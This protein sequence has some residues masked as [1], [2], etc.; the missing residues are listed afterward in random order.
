[1][2]PRSEFVT[3]S[4]GE[5]AGPSA[6]GDLAATLGTFEEVKSARELKPRGI[7]AASAM[8]LIDFVGG[9]L[10]NINSLWDLVTKI[11]GALGKKSIR[12][13]RVTL[14][15][16]ARIELESVTRDELAQ[17]IELAGGAPARGH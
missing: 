10:G 9:V 6:A 13:A 8:V 7:D 11:R 17:L 3:L 16:G 12:G 15:N 1:M 4:L 5:D 14:P 2:E